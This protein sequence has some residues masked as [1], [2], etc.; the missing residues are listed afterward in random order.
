MTLSFKNITERDREAVAKDV[1]SENKTGHFED[2]KYQRV[3]PIQPNKKCIENSITYHSKRF[4][5]P[6]NIYHS[7]ANH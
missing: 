4:M 1:R 2:I 7:N 5:W 6:Y 3:K